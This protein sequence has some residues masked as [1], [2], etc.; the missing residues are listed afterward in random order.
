MSAAVALQLFDDRGADERGATIVAR[1]L[2]DPGQHVGRD[3]NGYGL[4]VERRSS[5]RARC[6]GEGFGFQENDTLFC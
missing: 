2:V 1:Q 6:S 3:A 4:Q 5:H